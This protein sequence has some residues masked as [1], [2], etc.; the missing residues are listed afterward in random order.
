MRRAERRFR[1][2]LGLIA[3]ARSIGFARAG[4]VDP[5][6]LP[7]LA[8]QWKA[9]RTSAGAAPGGAAPADTA[10]GLEETWLL[11][12]DEWSKHSSVLVCC[13]SCRRD[14]PD[15]LS[16]P[17]DPHALVAPFA[18]AH[19]YRTAV[20][21]LRALAARAEAE[22][23]IDHRATRIFT[24]S[25]I[26]EKPLLV[27][28]GLGAMGKNG[29]CIVPGLGSLF[30]IAG[31]I[32]PVPTASVLPSPAA[33]A[34]APADPCGRCQSCLHACPVGALVA[35][36]ILDPQRCLQA[37][38]TSTEAFD[39]ATLEA[40]GTRLYGCQDCQSCC[41]H[42]VRLG[43]VEQGTAPGVAAP[44]GEIGPSISVRLLLSMDAVERKALFRGTA[45]GMSWVPDAA[46]VRNTLVAAGS[47]GDAAVAGAVR[48]YVDAREPAV[49]SAAR[50]ALRRLAGSNGLA[51]PGREE[52]EDDEDRDDDVQDQRADR[53]HA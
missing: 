50:W 25:R 12:P 48:R 42:N 5:S 43:A 9:R 3:L 16:A 17:G 7:P 1:E 8:A 51:S 20:D 2:E 44:G 11:S 18:R 4:F 36:G 26:P 31:I 34:A 52:R 22:H 6:L 14:E 23:G 24:N 40:W 27:A 30:V 21:M 10:H 45:M 53:G 15:D 41:P 47:S 19:Y 46:L 37:C 28:A 33:A 38:A 39:E 29:L 13:L 49:R 32:L 35:P